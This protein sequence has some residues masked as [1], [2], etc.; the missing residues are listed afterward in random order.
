MSRRRWIIRTG[1]SLC[2][3]Y[4]PW[5]T[6]WPILPPTGGGG[7]GGYTTPVLGVP[8][9]LIPV[10]SGQAFEISCDTDPMIVQLE[11]IQVALSGLCGY[12]VVLDL[13]SEDGLPGELPADASYGAGLSVALLKDGS[14]VSEMPDGASFS[15]GFNVASGLAGKQ[16]AALDWI[17][18]EWVPMDPV[19]SINNGMAFISMDSLGTCILV[20]Y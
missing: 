4:D 8:S 3:I 11:G 17:N 20:G 1:V 7:G 19:P 16:L 14:P 18:G 10:T 9:A 5:L 12:S 6:T 15:V 13:V 2:V